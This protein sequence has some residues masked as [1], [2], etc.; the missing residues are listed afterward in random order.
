MGAETF[1]VQSPQSQLSHEVDFCTW[2]GLCPCFCLWGLGS[3]CPGLPH[4][5]WWGQRSQSER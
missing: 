5:P 4:L 1:P 3:G 2:T